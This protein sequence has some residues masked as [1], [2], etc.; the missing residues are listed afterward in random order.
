MYINFNYLIKWN[1]RC[2]IWI[3]DNVNDKVYD[4]VRDKEFVSWIRI[5]IVIYLYIEYIYIS[6]EYEMESLKIKW[7]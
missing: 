5:G 3:N 1:L 6:L 7:K 4:M 2:M